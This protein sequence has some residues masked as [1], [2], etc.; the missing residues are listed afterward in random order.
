MG[1]LHRYSSARTWAALRPC[2]WFRNPPVEIMSSRIVAGPVLPFSSGFTRIFPHGGW[3]ELQKLTSALPKNSL[4][5]GLS[6]WTVAC[7]WIYTMPVPRAEWCSQFGDWC[8]SWNGIL[9][10]YPMWIS[11]STVW[12]G[13]ELEDQT[14]NL[15]RNLRLLSFGTA[16]T[17][18]TMTFLFRIGPSGDGLKWI[19]HLGRKNSTTLN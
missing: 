3:V 18:I 6:S 4:P 11:C 1:E 2:D 7:M 19:C 14:I 17:K 8:S 12:I 13:P 16:A 5:F 9:V 15:A 10:W